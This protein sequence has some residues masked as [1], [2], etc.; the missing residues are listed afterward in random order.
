[1]D[2][3]KLDL[4]ARFQALHPQIEEICSVSGNSGLSIGVLHECKVIHRA[5]FGYRDVIAKLAVWYR[6]GFEVVHHL[7]LID[8]SRRVVVF[9]FGAKDVVLISDQCVSAL[10][11]NV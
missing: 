1:M 2:T 10:C 9:T 5:N 11:F 7:E 4:E 3:A 6:L 8:I